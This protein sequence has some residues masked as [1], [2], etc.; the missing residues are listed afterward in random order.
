[1]RILFYGFNNRESDMDSY[2]FKFFIINSSIGIIRAQIAKDFTWK[3]ATTSKITARVKLEAVK[4]KLCFRM[5]NSNCCNCK[6]LRIFSKSV[7]LSF[8]YVTHLIINDI[9]LLP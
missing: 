6:L 4:C 3:D 9:V 2:G 5:H 7:V 8:L 1:M